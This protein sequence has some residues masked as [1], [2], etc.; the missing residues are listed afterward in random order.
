MSHYSIYNIN[1]RTI[2]AILGR[3]LAKG[4]SNSSIT[5]RQAQRT[6][7]KFKLDLQEISSSPEKTQERQTK[8][9][10]TKEEPEEP[11]LNINEDAIL[12]KKLNIFARSPERE[13]KVNIFNNIK[14]VNL[15]TIAQQPGGLNIFKDT[16]SAKP[17]VTSQDDDEGSQH[18]GS[19]PE[20][21]KHQEMKVNG[22][23]QMK[24]A[25]EKH[26]QKVG[27]FRVAKFRAGEGVVK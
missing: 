22:E 25:Y 23:V 6:S 16:F 19:E 12:Q 24:F 10:P 1:E 15:F 3:A 13:N 8:A 21:P 27:Q 7:Q 18:S 17:L 5:Q 14:S 4:R 26:Y 2:I 9:S 20:D 11:K